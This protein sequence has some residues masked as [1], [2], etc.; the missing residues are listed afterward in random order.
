MKKTTLGPMSCLIALAFI[1]SG[2]VGGRSEL[3]PSKHPDSWKRKE[4]R[5]FSRHINNN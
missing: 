4:D 5:H 2:C 3:D 1:L